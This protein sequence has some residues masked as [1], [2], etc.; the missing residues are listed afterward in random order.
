MGMLDRII[1]LAGDSAPPGDRTAEPFRA[2]LEPHAKEWID[3]A[4]LMRRLG[5]TCQSRDIGHRLA[6]LD[7]FIPND[8][9]ASRTI[10]MGRS[11]GARV[12]SRFAM[13]RPVRAVV[14]LAYPFRAPGKVL[15]PDRFAH[16]ATIPVPTLIVQPR[17]DPYGG[18][19]VTEHYALS[20]RVRVAFTPG[21]HR[22]V[23]DPVELDRLSRLILEFC[24][25]AASGRVCDPPPFDE[26]FYRACY[27]DVDEA[28]R[29]GRFAS[30]WEHFDRCGRR[31]G[32]RC[33][34]LPEAEPARPVARR[35]A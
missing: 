33:R 30:G 11:S 31:E 28:V 18:S 19:D 13:A 8:A 12:A 17:D 2:S 10:L 26:A 14:C 29:A 27:P 22:L 35:R 4:E 25:R 9:A 6:L 16:L 21:D 3:Q 23:P 1:C 24:R 32:R 20:P 15:E 5:E 34:I 7:A